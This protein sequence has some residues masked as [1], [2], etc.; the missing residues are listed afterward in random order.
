MK[1]IGAVI[2]NDKTTLIEGKTEDDKPRYSPGYMSLGTPIITAAD[3]DLIPTVSVGKD[4]GADLL[5]KVESTERLQ[6]HIEVT[7]RTENIS[8][9]VS[10]I[11]NYVHETLTQSSGTTSSRSLHGLQPLTI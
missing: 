2:I 1:A 3:K 9:Y 4:V 10:T 11:A 7:S 6:V 5:E 8:S